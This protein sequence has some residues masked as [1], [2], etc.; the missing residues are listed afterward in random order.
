VQL[1]KKYSGKSEYLTLL[2]A[3]P[4]VV[5]DGQTDYVLVIPDTGNNS[6]MTV[7]TDWILADMNGK[8]IEKVDGDAVQLNGMV[9]SFDS[10][11]EPYERVISLKDL[12]NN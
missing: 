3:L 1:T 12:K 2:Y 5:Q 7:Y 8:A 6:S 11:Y 9:L 4:I 10:M